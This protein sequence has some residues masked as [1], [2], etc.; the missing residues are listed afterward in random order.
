MRRMLVR[1]TIWAGLVGL[2]VFFVP[3]SV[4]TVLFVRWHEE[5][6]GRCGV[7]QW[8]HNPWWLFSA[9]LSLAVLASAIGLW[10]SIRQADRFVEPLQRLTDQAER[11]GSGDARYERIQSG[12]EEIDRVSDVLS[13]SAQQ[14]LTSLSVERD[15]ASDASHQLR[16]P[17]TALLMRLE[18]ISLTDDVT[19]AQ[20]EA[21]IAIEQVE[22]LNATVDALLARSRGHTPTSMTAPT[23]LDAVLARLQ[24]EWMPA[25]EAAQRTVRVSGERGLRLV[26]SQVA[27]AQILST[28][29]ENSLVHG[30][31]LVRIDAR[32]SGPS[33]VIEVSDQGPG[34]SPELAPHIFERS[35][36]TKSTGLGLGLARDLA[37][38]HGGRLELVQGYPV[39]FAL[40]LSA[41]E[42][43]TDGGAQPSVV[44]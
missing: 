29:I 42:P 35:V 44:G 24:R 1:S 6:A 22:R 41:V 9:G 18:E 28:L 8:G 39:V 37:E 33:G 3:V 14:L 5:H 21:N 12:I 23:S 43:G 31:G 40:F 26:T 16:T 25:F 11:L 20:E 2:V 30:R 17:L 4:L 15:F 27:L 32:R 10:L 36:S 7:S 38:S 34:V 19:V 13:R